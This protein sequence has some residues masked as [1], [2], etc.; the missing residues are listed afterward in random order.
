[1]RN[2]IEKMLDKVPDRLLGDQVLLT[3]IV[4]IPANHLRFT[5]ET[6]FFLS[7]L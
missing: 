2:I 6:I 5:I 7:F 4:T 1:M 3:T